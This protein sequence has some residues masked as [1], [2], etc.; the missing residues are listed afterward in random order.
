MRTFNLSKATRLLFFYFLFFAGLYYAKGFLVPLS[1]AGVLAMVMLPLGERLEGKG[2]S[3]G[4]AALICTLLLLVIFAG[5]GTLVIWQVSDILSDAGNLQAQFTKMVNK[6]RGWLSN[7]LG[8]A[9]E[10]QQQMLRQQQSSSSSKAAQTIS[11]IITGFGGFLAHSV[12]VMV[13]IYLFLYFRIHLRTFVLR[14][15]APD[16]RKKTSEIVE[17]STGVA[18]GYMS[19]MAMMIGCLWIMY[20]IGFSIVGVKNALFFAILC[21]LLEIVPFVGNLTGTATT[22]LFSLANGAEINTVISIMVVYAIVQFVQ[23][24]LLEPLVVGRAV[25]INP[26]ATILVIVLGEIVWG[27][28]G[29]ILA[30]PMLGIFKIVFDHVPGLEPYGFLVG[31]D[32]KNE[33]GDYPIIR[34]IK[35]LFGKDK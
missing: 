28:P 24:Y 2:M 11:G 13:Y 20:G 15:T 6:V 12:L 10:Q 8:I 33:A 23:S 7:T 30:L 21:G 31:E 18:S 16:S 27:I 34:S 9:P 14:L 25:N 17:R 19:G 35:R 1:I 29:M 5:L 22:I 32:E 4:F 26:L 3:R